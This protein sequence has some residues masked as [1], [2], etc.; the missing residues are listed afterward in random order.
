M[1]SEVSGNNSQA[2][3]KVLLLYTGLHVTPLEKDK[4][5]P[6]ELNKKNITSLLANKLLIKDNN[7][8]GNNPPRSPDCSFTRDPHGSFFNLIWKTTFV[9]ILKTIGAPDKLAK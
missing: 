7:P 1:S 5:H 9:G 4:K 6:G 2:S 8:S 3:G